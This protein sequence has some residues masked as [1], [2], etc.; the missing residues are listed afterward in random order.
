MH[1]VRFALQPGEKDSLI[2]LI[3]NFFDKEVKTFEGFIS[4]KLH[5]NEEGTVLINYA[6]WES[7]E[8]FQ[9]FVAFAANSDISKQIQAFKPQSDR[10]YELV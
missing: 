9:K 8:H 2:A 3:R 4:F 7:V 6:T 1:Y 10:V 5:A